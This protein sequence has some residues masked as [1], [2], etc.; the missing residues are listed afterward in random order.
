MKWVWLQI[1]RFP[2]SECFPSLILI[3]KLP[4]RHLTA[5]IPTSTSLV[6]ISIRHFIWHGRIPTQESSEI[7]SD[8]C[9]PIDRLKWR[10]M[11]LWIYNDFGLRRF[12]RWLASVQVDSTLVALDSVNWVNIVWLPEV[13][14][15]ICF[16]VCNIE[17]KF[18]RLHDGK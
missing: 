4:Q 6:G 10:K 15:G 1:C 8:I 13:N 12:I 3:T 18:F 7:E 5:I 14:V 11:P 16:E 9:I 2:R 17:L